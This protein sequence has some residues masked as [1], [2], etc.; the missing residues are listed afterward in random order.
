MLLP[1]LE[2]STWISLYTAAFSGHFLTTWI[3]GKEFQITKKIVSAALSVPLIQR[4]TYPYTESPPLDYFM[5]LLCGRPITWGSEPRLHS[6]EL[7]EFNYLMFR[8]TCHNIFS[9]THVHTNSIDR[10]TFLHALITDVTT[11]RVDFSEYRSSF[12]PP[13]PSNDWWLPLAIRNKKGE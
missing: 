8:I 3:Q 4:P 5:S 9:I 13:P 10:C 6:H 12:P 2:N 7:T 11:L 1:W